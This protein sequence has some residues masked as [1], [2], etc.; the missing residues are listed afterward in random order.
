M[1]NTLFIGVRDKIALDA[2]LDC[3]CK[4]LATIGIEITRADLRTYRVRDGVRTA[5]DKDAI[6]NPS[7]IEI[8]LNDDAPAIRVTQFENEIHP[9]YSKAMEPLMMGVGIWVGADAITKTVAACVAAAAAVSA[10]TRVED[11]EHL[12]SDQDLNDPHEFIEKVKVRYKSLVEKN[13]FKP[14]AHL[15]LYFAASR[16]ADS[17][18]LQFSFGHF[19][20]DAFAEGDAGLFDGAIPEIAQGHDECPG[21]DTNEKFEK[22]L[23]GNFHGDAGEKF[24][25]HF[26]QWLVHQID[27]IAVN[28][29]SSKMLETKLR[30]PNIWTV[31]A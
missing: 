5:L 23:D 13:E 18:G 15:N 20:D 11:A 10:G 28:A 21:G 27:A 2:I 29:G 6:D 30:D 31:A 3:S 26:Q 16:F 7:L 1:D 9:G 12:W 4:F 19:L 24:C 22:W 8:Y 25:S 14:L 17:F